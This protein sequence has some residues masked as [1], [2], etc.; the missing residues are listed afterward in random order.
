[1]RDESFSV[2]VEDFGE[3][4]HRTEVPA[5]SLDRWRG[6]L[7][8]Q[9]LSYWRDEGWGGYRQGLFWLV[10]PALF[11]DLVDEWLENSPLEGVDAFHVIARTAFG[12]LFLCGEQT[13]CSATIAVPLNTLF[14]RQDRLRKKSARE[15]DISVRA[16]MG[17]SPK[18]CDFK[19][20]AGRPLFDR[21]LARLGP[22][23]VDEVF[24]FEPAL[25]AGGR[26]RLEQ[27]HKLKLDQHLTI[28]RQLA[29]PAG[30]VGA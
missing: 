29:G 6:R 10:D 3:P 23:Q 13:G 17:L 18:D 24:G 27:L 30:P 22:L 1:M 26:P 16:F 4:T 21:A 19:D 20:D 9:L 2:F 5:S 11:E 7:P 25:V 15:L 28:L 8:D 12:D 14:A